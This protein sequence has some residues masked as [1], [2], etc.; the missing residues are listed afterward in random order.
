MYITV[1]ELAS[2]AGKSFDSLADFNSLCRRAQSY[3]DYYTQGRLKRADVVP[4]EVKSAML[5]I[6]ER[7]LVEN[8]EVVS[9][10]SDGV[11]VKLSEKVSFDEKIYEIIKRN[12][13]GELLYL[14]VD[15]NDK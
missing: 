6:C 11:S 8:A 7:L 13:P 12:L 2:Y 1:D 9:Y 14:G 4:Q 3:V 5:E 10:A 15:K